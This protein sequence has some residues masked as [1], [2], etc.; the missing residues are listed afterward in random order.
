MDLVADWLIKNDLG[1]YVEKFEEY[2]WDD[3]SLLNKMTEIDI[4]MCIQKP[5]HKVK[6][7]TALGREMVHLSAST[8]TVRDV[9]H[10]SAS[11]QTDT[12][13]QF[14]QET[15]DKNLVDEIAARITTDLNI[16]ERINCA[17]EKVIKGFLDDFHEN[18]TNTVKLVSGTHNTSTVTVTCPTGGESNELKKSSTD[19]ICAE[20]IMILPDNAEDLKRNEIVLKPALNTLPNNKM[21]TADETQ[22]RHLTEACN[23]EVESTTSATHYKADSG[24]QYQS[25]SES[26]VSSEVELECKLEDCDQEL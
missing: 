19:A 18:V 3:K 21:V 4:L 5:G 2:G 10:A 15:E 12:A 13:I 17:V 6:F 11:T 23:H 26:E 25:G 14:G 9:V 8:Q 20:S 7:K 1:E 22:D 24:N 16:S